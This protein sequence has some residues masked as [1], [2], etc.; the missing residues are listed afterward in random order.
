MWELTIIDGE[1][2]VGESASAMAVGD[3]DGDGNVEIVVGG[4]DGLVWYRPATE[5]RG[6]IDSGRIAVGLALEDIDG[7]GRL[8]VVA[9]QWIDPEYRIVWHKAPDGLDGKWARH[10]LDGERNGGVHDLLFADVD[11]DGVREL[12][13]ADPYGG[14]ESIYLYKRPADPTVAWPKYVVQS[15]QLLEGLSA[16]DFD[17]DGR[18]EILCGPDLFFQPEGGPFAGPWRR[19][20]VAPS[21]REMSRTAAVD[22]T[23]NGRPDVVIAESEYLKG[24][25]SWFENRIVEDPANP[26]REHRL[27]DDLYYTHSLKAWREDGAVRVFAAEMWQG[28]WDG[29]PNY[30]GRMLHLTS[31]DNGASWT[32]ET[33]HKGEGTHQAQMV[34]IDGSGRRVVVGKRWGSAEHNPQVH[35]LRPASEPSSLL[36]YR[37]RFLDRAKP[38]KASDIFSVDITGNGLPDVACGPCWYRNPDWRPFEIPEIYQAILAYDVDGDGREEIIASTGPRPAD[39]P[40]SSRFVWLKPIDPEAGEWEQHPIGDGVGDWPHGALI[41]PI[42]PGGKPALVCAYHSAKKQDHFPDLFEIPDDPKQ[43]PWPRRTLIDWNFGEQM[44][45]ADLTGSGTVDLVLGTRWL[46]NMGDGTFTPHTIVEGFE[47]ARMKLAD[48]N[49]DGKLDVVMTE[50][51]QQWFVDDHSGWGH[52]LWFEQPGDPRE[53]WIRHPIDKMR[54]PHSLDVADLDGDGRLEIVACEH[55]PFR[56]EYH[57]QCRVFVYEPTNRGATVWKR[58]RLCNR[59]EHH[60]GAHVFD[61]EPGKPAIV[62]HGWKDFKYVHLWTRD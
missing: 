46:E 51:N 34:D 55:D 24:A 33:L 10:I 28:G 36:E 58:H 8:E 40:L 23:G 44:G 4:A 53:P 47:S 2:P 17:G 43:G 9:A 16:G 27:E 62:S 59:F 60:D 57:S 38:H 1:P 25:L 61:V 54:M 12:I 37:H 29:P 39:Y 41:A 18:M 20:T 3:I 6:V 52:L 30:E 50:E 21:F 45:A 32:H 42:L 56:R 7:D 11:G 26:W 5:D 31:R 49:G 48:L 14:M 19:T 15:G 22:I 35:I 13:A